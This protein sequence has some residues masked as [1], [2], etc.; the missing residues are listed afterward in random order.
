MELPAAFQERMRRQLGEA[1]F[2]QYLSILDEQ[3][4]RSLRIN[5]LKTD[6]PS[7]LAL[8]GEGLT[9]NGIVPEGFFIPDGFVVGKNPLHAAGLFYMQEPSAQLPAALLSAKPG[10]TV[11]DLCAAPG[12]KS[13]QLAQSMQ[14]TGLLIANEPVPNR[15]A[16]LNGTKERLG[17]R[18]TT[19]T[20][21]SPDVLC[22]AL[23][24]AVD[25]IMVDAPCS[26]EGMFRKE[27]DAI[28]DWSPEH[29]TSCADRQRAIL[30]SAAS[31]LK[32][33]GS[34][35]YSTCTFSSEE[36]E[37]TVEFFLH[38]H[39]EFVLKEQHKLFPHT[40]SGEGQ[41]AALLEKQGSSFFAANRIPKASFGKTDKR[42]METVL[43][44]LRGIFIELP[45][46]DIRILPDGRVFL[47]EAA[48]PAELDS[49]RLVSAGVFLGEL[50]KDRME[51]SHALFMAYPSERFSQSF[52]PSE[53]DLARFLAGESIGCDRSLSGYLPVLTGRYAIG[54]GKASNGTLKNHIP[55]GLRFR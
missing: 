1:A 21:L 44:T 38:K 32:P 35:V 37:E 16:V 39:P 15:A 19:V 40:S 33:G 8:A 14:N 29:V 17:L 27:P 4:P 36:D 30:E 20:C 25:R 26:G 7:F 53:D 47:L 23:S 45:E 22:P 24:E 2:G 54:F 3:R 34:L 10:E 28:R 41:Y 13:G 42:A 51:P 48:L 52:A 46:G 55:K 12:G 9:P 5:T 49:L 6:I 18:N 50:K 43:N 31:A 11:L